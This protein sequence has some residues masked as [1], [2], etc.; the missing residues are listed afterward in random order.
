MYIKKVGSAKLKYIAFLIFV[1]YNF[2]K[3]KDV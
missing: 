3:N 1:L 2:Y